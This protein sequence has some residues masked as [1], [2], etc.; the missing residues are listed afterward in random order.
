MALLNE[1]KTTNVNNG[2]IVKF[3]RLAD[4]RYKGSWCYGYEG[5]YFFHTQIY[6]EKQVQD[7]LIAGII[8]ITSPATLEQKY[9]EK[10]E[11]PA[12]FFFTTLDSRRYTGYIQDD[13]VAISWG[14]GI[15]TQVQSLSLKAF[16]ERMAS[17]YYRILEESYRS[18]SSVAAEFMEFMN[19]QDKLTMEDYLAIAETVLLLEKVMYNNAK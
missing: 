7:A 2:V 8:Y 19:K 10:R 15:N 1:F 14:E 6:T 5:E 4:M 18:A 17:G 13:V 9:E 16:K 12:R 3:K 11:L